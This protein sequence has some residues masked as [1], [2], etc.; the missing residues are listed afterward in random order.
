MSSMVAIPKHQF[1]EAGTSLDLIS[2][3]TRTV[4]AHLFEEMRVREGGLNGLIVQRRQPFRGDVF[5]WK[6]EGWMV[7]QQLFEA[8]DVSRRSDIV[9]HGQEHAP[10]GVPKRQGVREL[11]AVNANRSLD[12]R[13]DVRD[14]LD[15]VGRAV[16][17]VFNRD[18][19]DVSQLTDDQ[20]TCTLEKHLA[21]Q[22]VHDVV[23]KFQRT[24]QR[25]GRLTSF[26][27]AHRPVVLQAEKQFSSV[28]I[29]RRKRQGGQQR[30]Q[31][32]FVRHTDESKRT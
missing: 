27:V 14:V 30:P 23:T 11:A 12:V 28:R 25:F 26:N 16:L 19:V 3:A 5:T 6:S 7:Q 8:P 21:F 9:H 32:R 29:Q 22:V 20:G 31:G 2:P 18:F 24:N 10:H 17:T 4:P 15:G 1:V 13:C